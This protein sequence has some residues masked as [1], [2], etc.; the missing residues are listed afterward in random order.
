MVLFP[1][2]SQLS[3]NRLRHFSMGNALWEE[4]SVK[5]CSTMAQVK[6]SPYKHPVFLKYCPFSSTSHY[7]ESRHKE[8]GSLH[9]PLSLVLLC[10][11]SLQGTELQM[12]L[13]KRGLKVSRCSLELLKEKKNCCS[14]FLLESVELWTIGSEA[15][16]LVLLKNP[17]ALWVIYQ[18]IRFHFRI[19]YDKSSRFKAAPYHHTT[20]TMSDCCFHSCSQ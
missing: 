10:A 1:L 11:N 13:A 12:S 7:G 4:K 19:N 6:V 18:W 2:S 14:L 5:L 20:S 16:M 9:T 17:S 15:D 3:R 8:L